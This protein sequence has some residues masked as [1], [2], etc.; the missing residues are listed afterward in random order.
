MRSLSRFS[1]ASPENNLFD[2]D[3]SSILSIYQLGC[4]FRLLDCFQKKSKNPG[5]SQNP[6]GQVTNLVTRLPIL[7]TR[8]P[9]GNLGA[10]QPKIWRVSGERANESFWKFFIPRASGEQATRNIRERERVRVLLVC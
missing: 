4:F 7:V 1:C 5:F 2:S 9:I 10:L 8:L 3:I 6:G